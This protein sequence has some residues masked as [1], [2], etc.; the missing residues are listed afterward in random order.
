[1][2]VRELSGEDRDEWWVRAVAAYPPYAEYQEHTERPIPV[3]LA[4]P[5]R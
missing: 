2:T 3:L 1:M 4:T 5:R